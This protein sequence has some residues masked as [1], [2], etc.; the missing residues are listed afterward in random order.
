MQ[1]LRWL[2]YKL[3]NVFFDGLIKDTV[4]TAPVK[5]GV[6]HLVALGR[7]FN[8]FQAAFYHLKTGDEGPQRNVVREN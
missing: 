7:F 5:L 8:F 3:C 1:R 4:E 2:I 6:R